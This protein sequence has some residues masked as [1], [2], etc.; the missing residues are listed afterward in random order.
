LHDYKQHSGEVKRTA[1]NIQKLYAR[2]NIHII[3]HYKNLREQVI[4]DYK[5]PENKVHQVYSGIFDI[6][7]CI[8]PKSISSLDGEVYILYFGRI[9]QYKGIDFLIRNFIKIQSKRSTKLVI[10]GNGKLWFDHD[11]ANSE[12]IIVNRYIETPELV[13]LIH[14]C[15]FVVVPYTDATHSATIMTAYAFNKPVVTSRIGGVK[16]VVDQ[17]K[18]GIMVQPGDENEFRCAL[19]SLIQDDDLLKR[20]STN[21]QDYCRSSHIS[22]QNVTQELCNVYNNILTS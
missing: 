19:E 15:R 10:A 13:Y 5:L 12:I 3:Q 9:S 7:N 8:T 21:I 4:N 2:S 17:N 14:N 18:T 22:W 11:E 20:M 16:E 6:F 1:Y